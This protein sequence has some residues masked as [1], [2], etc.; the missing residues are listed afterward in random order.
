MVSTISSQVSEQL[1]RPT[2]YHF[3]SNNMNEKGSPDKMQR[4]LQQDFFPHL[5]LTGLVYKNLKQLDL[6]ALGTVNYQVA[7]LKEL[8]ITYVLFQSASALRRFT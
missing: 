2:T 7:A 5:L 4:L 6:D 8:K 1:S 3:Y